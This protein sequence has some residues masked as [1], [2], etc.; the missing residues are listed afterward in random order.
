MYMYVSNAPYKSGS[1]NT[2]TDRLVWWRY[3]MIIHC[4]QKLHECM[5]RLN[6]Y[7]YFAPS[8]CKHT[9]LPCVGLGLGEQSHCKSWHYVKDDQQGW[10][11]EVLWS[12][13]IVINKDAYIWCSAKV[14]F[15]PDLR[16]FIIMGFFWLH[17]FE[18]IFT[19]FRN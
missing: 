14:C 7:E 9:G 17:Y 5:Y 2:I 10:K 15:F 19:N 11:K 16:F 1:T 6:L 3:I 18:N 12:N 13:Q 8:S 4:L